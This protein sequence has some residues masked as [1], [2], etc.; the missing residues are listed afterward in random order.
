[1]GEK[2]PKS[3]QE[4]LADLTATE[5]VLGSALIGFDGITI[6]ENFVVE[7]ND[8]KL[9]ALLSSVYNR[10]QDV[11]GE[12]RQGNVRQAWF[13]TE[14]YVFVMRSTPVGLLV[15]VGRHE[16]PV[17]LIHLSMRKAVGEVEK[18]DRRT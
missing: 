5:G 6:A 18:L 2:V 15:A 1:M 14:R 16:A 11:F 3:V 4:I 9:G 13:E 7:V 10:L 8:E 17:G 12:L